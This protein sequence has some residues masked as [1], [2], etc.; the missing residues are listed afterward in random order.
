MLILEYRQTNDY[1]FGRGA[2]GVK[3]GGGGGAEI[4]DLLF[5]IVSELNNLTKKRGRG[6]R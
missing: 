4:I 2:N 1:A 6:H 5:N 3:N